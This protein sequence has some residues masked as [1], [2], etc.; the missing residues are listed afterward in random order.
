MTHV[1]T[2]KC[3]GCKDT[4][5]ALACPIEC[6][7][8]G[9]EMLYIDSDECIDCEVCVA[10]CPVDAIFHEDDVPQESV[11]DIEMNKEMVKIYPVF[12]G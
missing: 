11:S 4:S 2:Q 12:Q 1:V 8:V 10:E 7:H 9:P 6:F 3:V 5:C